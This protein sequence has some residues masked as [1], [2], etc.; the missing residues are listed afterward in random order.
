MTDTI[1]P[2]SGM[3]PLQATRLASTS[4]KGGP[5]SLQ[6]FLRPDLFGV[7]IA[8]KGKRSLGELKPRCLSASINVDI[9]SKGTRDVKRS[10]ANESDLG[11]T[12]VVTPNRN[13]ALAAAIDVVWTINTGNR[14]GFQRPAYDLDG[15]S[16][17]DRI[18]NKCAACVSLTIRAVAAVH[19][20]RRGQ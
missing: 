18:N 8:P 20:D 6:A 3:E 9:R 4:S 17:N 7:I 5:K 2:R 1:Q 15:R 16:F 10:N 13:L 11:P 12:P 14:S 19:A